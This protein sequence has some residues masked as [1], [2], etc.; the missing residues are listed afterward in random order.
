MA[1]G[2]RGWSQSKHPQSGKATRLAS[3]TTTREAWCRERG[4]NRGIA[5]RP[6]Q[7]YPSLPSKNV[8]RPEI[9][10]DLN[11][12]AALLA[13]TFGNTA[14]YDRAA[15]RELRLLSRDADQTPSRSQGAE[16]E[17]GQQRGRLSAENYIAKPN[18]KWK[19]ESERKRNQCKEKK[20]KQQAHL[21][22][23]DVD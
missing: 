3:K 22:S 21:G 13:G 9:C 18:S 2:S 19:Q 14:A 20:R 4:A 10:C 15:V 5:G 1:Q 6:R 23:N 7:V 17:T 12:A 16:T 11:G 8:P